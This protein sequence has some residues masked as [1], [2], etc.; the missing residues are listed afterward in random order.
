MMIRQS[1]LATSGPADSPTPTTG[2]A[3]LLLLLLWMAAPLPFGAVLPWPRAAAQIAALLAFVLVA[4]HRDGFRALRHAAWPAAAVAM[5]GLWGALQAM[6]WPPLVA[7]AVAPRAVELWRGAPG[8]AAIH[9]SSAPSVSASTALQWLGVAAALAAASA[10]GVSRPWRRAF[11]V[12]LLLVALFEI[13]Y[14]FHGLARSPR[15][16]WGVEVPGASQR[17]RG[18][19]INPNHLAF[20]LGLAL[21]ACQAWLWWAV[22]RF[23]R[24]G[25]GWERVVLALTLAALLVA[26]LIGTGSRGG[27]LAWLVALGVQ[28]VVLARPR[29]RRGGRF[30]GAALGGAAL[31][32]GGLAVFLLYRG[33]QLAR[34]LE[35]SPAQL[36]LRGRIPAWR[37]SLELWREAPWAGTG[38]GTFRQAFPR[39]QPASLGDRWEHAHND[40]LELLVTTGIVGPLLVGA[41]LVFGLR[42]LRR[43]WRRGRRS[44][45][46]GAALAAFGALGSVGAHSLVEFGLT[47]PAN[48]FVFAIFCGLALGA[49]VFEPPPRVELLAADP[50]A[51][52]DPLD[53]SPSARILHL[54]PSRRPRGSGRS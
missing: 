54:D 3:A 44:E 14:G 28:A 31:F 1:F 37:A 41:A 21:S 43:V 18:T 30:V 6:S 12:A 24:S 8:D 22:R 25:R 42:R 29:R 50:P 20:F 46:R 36:S 47:M 48:A 51:P 49:P 34:W 32:L 45:E 10:V 4:G 13:A 26:G 5:V 19:F 23:R 39:V 9:L 7:R 53:E 2:L 27:Q 52:S 40:V 15:M 17:L 33:G 38:L 16:I 35:L 11:F